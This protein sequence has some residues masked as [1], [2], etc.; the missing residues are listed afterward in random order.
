MGHQKFRWEDLL[1]VLTS[2]P[3]ST[4]GHGLLLLPLLGE[5]WN[6]GA[7]A[8][9]RLRAGACGSRPGGVSECGHHGRSIAQRQIDIVE[10][11]ARYLQPAAS[12]RR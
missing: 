1:V 8:P 9:R 4:M 10:F 7:I 3:I 11:L 6:L 12:A 2:T 5:R